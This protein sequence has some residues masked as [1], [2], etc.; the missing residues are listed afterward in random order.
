MLDLVSCWLDMYILELRLFCG[1]N[2]ALNWLEK[3]VNTKEVLLK[4]CPQEPLGSLGKSTI[5]CYTK[6]GIE[7]HLLHLKLELEYYQPRKS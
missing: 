6:V 3:L 2:E 4:I 7:F 1:K 5:S